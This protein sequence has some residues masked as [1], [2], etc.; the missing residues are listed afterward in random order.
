MT[1]VEPG[2]PADKAGIKVGDQILTAN[3]QDIPAVEALI[4][5]LNRTKDQPLELVVLRNGQK[6]TFTVK[7]VLDAGR[8]LRQGPPT[9]S[10]SPAFPPKS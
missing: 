10:A 7:P 5:M 2:M 1:L 3:G 9:G 8:R 4:Q 6:L